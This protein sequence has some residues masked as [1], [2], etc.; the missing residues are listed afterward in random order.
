MTLLPR[1]RRTVFCRSRGTAEIR[2]VSLIGARRRLD[3]CSQ[4][5]AQSPLKSCPSTFNWTDA[6]I[7]AAEM[8]SDIYEWR[9]CSAI[10]IQA[11][12]HATSH[13]S[14]QA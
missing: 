2:L 8:L 6:R 7:W 11:L 3:L 14:I 12:S 5:N 13:S 1:R 10:H 9:N 4:P